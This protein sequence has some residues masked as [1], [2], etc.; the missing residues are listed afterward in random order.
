MG[1]IIYDF[2]D[3]LER[4]KLVF[5]ENTHR[6]RDYSFWVLYLLFD[7]IYCC[8]WYA[9][10]HWAYIN[11]EDYAFWIFAGTWVLFIIIF[12][13]N[14]IVNLQKNQNRKKH[15]KDKLLKEANETNNDLN[16]NTKNMEM[17]NLKEN[18]H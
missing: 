16:M 1:K 12:I 17:K 6:C 8:A 15:K 18:N 11:H 10:F 3:G 4:E 7:W 14:S 9:L 13:A 5:Q 2:R